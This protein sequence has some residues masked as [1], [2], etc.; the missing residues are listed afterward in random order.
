M[1]PKLTGICLGVSACAAYIQDTLSFDIFPEQII[2]IADTYVMREITWSLA[3]MKY[4]I[5]DHNTS[6]STPQH[7]I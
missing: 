7:R 1:N 5:A 3:R 2:L 4:F 6:I